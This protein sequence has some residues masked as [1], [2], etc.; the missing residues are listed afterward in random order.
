MQEIS[1]LGAE[2]A[3]ALVARNYD[4]IRELMDPEIDFRAMTPNR[5]W[6]AGDPDTVISD[7]LLSWFDESNETV[8]LE[9]LE[10]DAF[11][12]RERVGFRLSVRNAEGRHLVEQQVYLSSRDGRITW[13]RSVCSGFRPVDL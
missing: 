11:A 8:A 5:V 9:R 6:E 1:T 3:R 7:V 12:D 4:R 10:C 13:M 2:Y